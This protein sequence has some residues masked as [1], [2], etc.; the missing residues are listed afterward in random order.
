MAERPAA[1]WR[2]HLKRAV[3]IALVVAVV[4]GAAAAYRVYVHLPRFYTVIE[5]ELTR[6]RQ[7]RYLNYWKLQ[8]VGVE[9]LI[10]LHP[11][12]ERPDDIAYER[13]WAAEHDVDFVH[14]PMTDNP[15]PT[16]D[17]VRR[18]LRAVRAADGPVHFHCAAGRRRSSI[19]EAAWHIVMNDYTVAEAMQNMVDRGHD[20]EDGPEWRQHEDL[21]RQVHENRQELFRETVPDAATGRA[22]GDAS[23]ED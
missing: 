6:S 14:I 10:V 17:H 12:S 4:G 11:E 2:A 1:P 13:R 16:L 23:S 8:D 5:G 18:F 22:S 9:R 15:L 21:M 3:L 19:M 20:M 7:P